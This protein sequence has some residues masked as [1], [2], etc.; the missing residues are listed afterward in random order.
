MLFYKKALGLNPRISELY[1]KVGYIY[2]YELNNTINAIEMYLK[3]LEYEP[4]DYGLN[5]N[6]M[7]AYFSKEDI[8]N[9]IKHYKVLSN[10]RKGKERFSDILLIFV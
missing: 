10:I 8:T 3:G 1:N 5:L 2:Q 7:Y 9:G 4:N 6:I